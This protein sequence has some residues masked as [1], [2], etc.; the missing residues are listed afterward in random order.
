MVRLKRTVAYPFF[1]KIVA[2]LRNDSMKPTSIFDLFNGALVVLLGAF[3]LVACSNVD[4]D[5]VAEVNQALSVKT[6]VVGNSVNVSSVAK[7][8]SNRLRK[9]RAVHRHLELVGTTKNTSDAS[10]VRTLSPSNSALGA[11]TSST[12]NASIAPTNTF[13]GH[14]GTGWNPPDTEGAVSPNFV[15]STVNSAMSVRSRNGQELLGMELSTFWSG[16]TNAGQ[17][18]D[19]RIRYDAQAQRFILLSAGGLGDD[20]NSG[21]LIA[22][23]E[24]SDPTGKWF[25]FR[26]KIDPNNVAWVDY[27][28]LGFNKNWVA[29]SGNL[30]NSSGE[31]TRVWAFNKAELYAGRA[32][33]STLPGQGWTTQVC[34]TYDAAEENLFLMRLEGNSSAYLYRI[35]GAI[36]NERV[37]TVASVDAPL[38]WVGAPTAPQLGSSSTMAT[39]HNWMLGCT[40]RNGSVWGNHTV[41]PLDGPARAAVQWW[42]LS[43]TG[44]LQD[45]GRIDDPTGTTY[46]GMSSLAVNKNNDVLI[47]YTRFSA[48]TYPSAGYALRMGT[49]PAGSFRSGTVYKS[50]E[51]PYLGGD[52]WGDYSHSQVDPTNDTDFWTVQEYSTSTGGWGTWWASV[53]P[54][55]SLCSSS[56]DCE[57]GVFCNGAETCSAG[58]C[59]SGVSWG[60]QCSN[61][62]PLVRYQYSGA[63]GTGERW[64]VVS[65]TIAGWQANGVY[66]RIIRVNGVVVRPGEMPLPAPIN[67][68]R[69][70][71]VTAGSFPYGSMSIW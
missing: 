8:D 15:V 24:T 5:E 64:F 59:I 56:S 34:E 53:S 47:G 63:F 68:K 69:Y 4:T 48:D 71:Q 7:G 42:R 14:E 17:A 18:F 55:D 58:Q 70:F 13:L 12:N 44:T 35:T 51:A 37:E 11:S 23:T 20:A 10:A 21:L 50:G 1:G 28:T 41:Q 16:I 19:S 40:V 49:D 6:H 31:S 46:Y 22:V 25:R 26:I 29:V 43:T 39:G 45:F 27:P 33:F 66:D 62:T 67:G 54:D 61:A 65:D 3:P 57:D 9:N 36:G 52:R 38:S 60:N 2:Q 32:S 30:V